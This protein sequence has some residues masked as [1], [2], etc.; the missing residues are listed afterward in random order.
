ME[1]SNCNNGKNIDRW[2]YD[3]CIPKQTP[4]NSGCPNISQFGILTLR[5]Y[6]YY[7]FCPKS[8]V[9]VMYK[10]KLINNV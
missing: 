9:V 10:W 7:D 1:C 3:R 5:S 8:M 2:N 6:M 4:L